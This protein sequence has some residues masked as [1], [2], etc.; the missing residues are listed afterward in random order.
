MALEISVP[1]WTISRAA[2]E[3]ARY[4]QMPRVISTTSSGLHQTRSRR[5][6]NTT[7]LEKWAG[8]C[9]TPLHSTGQ[10][11]TTNNMRLL[12]RRYVYLQFLLVKKI[13]QV[14]HIVTVFNK[15]YI[16][17][18]YVHFCSQVN[19]CITETDFQK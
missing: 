6:R 19:M 10:L 15:L 13:R 5:Y 12:Y 1:V 14:T 4:L 9:S 3:S 18:E 17:S 16:E 11:S 8:V 2:L 7:M